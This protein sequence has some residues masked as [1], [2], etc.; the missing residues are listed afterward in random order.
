M[1]YYCYIR[2]NNILPSNYSIHNASPGTT[3]YYDIVINDIRNILHLPGFPSTPKKNMY[4]SLLPKEDSLVE[5]QYPTLDW[6]NIWRNYENL[7]VYSFDK[8]IIYKHLHVC[9]A[10]NKKLFTMGLINSSKCNNCTVDR[11][12]TPIHIFYECES[13]KL[14]FMWLI[15]ML[16]YI[17]NF[18][19]VS[20]IR[21]IYYDNKYRNRQQQNICNI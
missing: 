17:T 12:Q 5:S 15:K 8:E 14:L 21:F 16:F 2:L 18:K 20:N 11:E 13:V 7:Y 3:S 19:P 1:Y 4:I 9:L 6:Q 10:T